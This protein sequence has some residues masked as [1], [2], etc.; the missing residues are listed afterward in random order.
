MNKL[1]EI[2][3]LNSW[4]VYY[5]NLN[6]KNITPRFHRFG[7]RDGWTMDKEGKRVRVKKHIQVQ[8][9]MQ[10]PILQRVHLTPQVRVKMGTAVTRHFLGEQE[11]YGKIG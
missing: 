7:V 11:R 2:K 6:G 5:N 3:E 9:N 8:W 1:A 4:I 10:E